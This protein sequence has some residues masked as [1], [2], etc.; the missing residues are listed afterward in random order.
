MAAPS[1]AAAGDVGCTPCDSAI[2]GDTVTGHHVLHIDCYARTKDE[3]PTGKPIKS[4][5]FKIGD[6]SWRI[7]YYPNGKSAERAEFIAV[8][9][10]LGKSV[11]EPFNARARFSLV[12]REGNPDP[13]LSYGATGQF[14][15][16]G[17]GFGFSDFVKK[18]WLEKSDLLLDD[19]F[20]I[21]CD[22][23]ILKDL[24]TVDRPTPPPR[25]VVPPSD[26]NQH[27]GNLLADEDGFDVTFQVAGETFRA[28]KNILKARSPVFKAE[29]FGAMRES[30]AAA[31]DCIQIDDMLPQVFKAFLHFLYTD[32]LPYGLMERHEAVAMAQHLLEAADR[33]D[34]PRLKLMC[35]DM[36]CRHIEVST[37]ATTLVLA[38][39]HNCKALKDACIEFLESS[40]NLEAVLATDG[41]DHLTVSCPAL[42]REL[43]SKLGTSSH[44]R[45]KLGPC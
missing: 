7:C 21:R 33:Y 20:K 9:L 8:F 10:V 40:D 11:A 36:L 5:P 38:E 22:V 16:R 41:F 28:H 23:T 37:A 42:M 32:L 2:V 25:V 35:E 15:V 29:L 3:V 6:Y 30:T 12:D 39:Q 44:K 27:L 24:T 26:L 4:L 43:L 45:R 14:S 18:E 1:S 17:V 31:G 34:M 19:C 13:V